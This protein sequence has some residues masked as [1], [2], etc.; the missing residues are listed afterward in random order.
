MGNPYQTPN[1]V[2]EGRKQRKQISV[3]EVLAIVAILTVLATLLL[4]AVQQARVTPPRRFV[5]DC[6][7]EIRLASED[8]LA[9]RG[10]APTHPDDLT[11]LIHNGH[12]DASLDGEDLLSKM[13]VTGTDYWGNPLRL[14]PA[15]DQPGVF[16]LRSA[17]ADGEFDR[18]AASDDIFVQYQT[19]IE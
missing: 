11:S 10:T 14:Q 17:G 4:P 15:S 16:E 2:D 18:S 6:M 13:L 8:S 5:R 7:L 9:T 12:V 3:I 1:T 19:Q